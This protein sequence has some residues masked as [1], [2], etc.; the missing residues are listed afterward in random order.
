MVEL[1]E[2][3]NSSLCLKYKEAFMCITYVGI[4]TKHEFNVPYIC[5]KIKHGMK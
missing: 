3:M 5:E 1:K 2:I 4:L